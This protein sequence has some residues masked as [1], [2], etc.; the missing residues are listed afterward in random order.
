MYQNR[1]H[2]PSVNFQVLIRIRKPIERDKFVA[3]RVFMS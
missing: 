2:Q 1:L 3:K